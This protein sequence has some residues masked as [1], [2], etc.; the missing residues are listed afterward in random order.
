M[1]RAEPAR[2]HRARIGDRIVAIGGNCRVHEGSLQERTQDKHESE[3]GN[4]AEIS[5]LHRYPGSEGRFIHVGSECL[6]DL[7]PPDIAEGLGG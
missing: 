2:T 7:N 4:A 1:N 6:A 3:R 5:H